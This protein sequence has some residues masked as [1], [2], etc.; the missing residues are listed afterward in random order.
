VPVLVAPECRPFQYCYGSKARFKT[1]LRPLADRT[2]Y[3]RF[4]REI[5][6][7]ISKRLV[8]QCLAFL[9]G[10]FICGLA[11]SEKQLTTS[12]EAA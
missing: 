5:S 3:P 4:H 1:E 9:V 7:I 11:F 10:A 8:D 12:A 2:R 6:L